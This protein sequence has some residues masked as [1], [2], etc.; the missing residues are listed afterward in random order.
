[1][2]ILLRERAQNGTKLTLSVVW[3]HVRAAYQTSSGAGVKNVDAAIQ[4]L[5]DAKPA[6]VLMAQARRPLSYRNGREGP[7]QGGRKASV[8]EMGVAELRQEL[9]E[10]RN[11][12][13]RLRK[14]AEPFKRQERG[15]ERVGRETGVDR[16]SSRQ[17]TRDTRRSNRAGGLGAWKGSQA[18]AV[19][20][21]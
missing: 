12:I 1:M 18:A 8:V 3:D 9:V 14:N 2:R 13:Y 4:L 6:R 7:G 10:S 15:C 16:T 21:P 17:S 5:T 11:T 19:L 20:A